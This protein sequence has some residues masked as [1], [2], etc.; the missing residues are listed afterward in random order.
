M[1]NNKLK[2]YLQDL[3]NQEIIHSDVRDEILNLAHIKNSQIDVHQF[4][5]T[6]M[7]M[8]GYPRQDSYIQAIKKLRL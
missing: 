8:L 1:D 6:S 3:V 7:K 5:K 2:E 4:L